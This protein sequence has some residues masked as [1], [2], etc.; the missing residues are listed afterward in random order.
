MRIEVRIRSL[1]CYAYDSQPDEKGT[2]QV[3]ENRE[4][5]KSEGRFLDM[6]SKSDTK[7]GD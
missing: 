7:S 6:I 5:K 4:D 3:Q 1:S 2:K